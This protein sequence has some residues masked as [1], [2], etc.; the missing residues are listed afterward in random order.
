MALSNELFDLLI[1]KTFCQE[2]RQNFSLA[3]IIPL[4]IWQ[5]VFKEAVTLR[6]INIITKAYS[7]VLTY[8]VTFKTPLLRPLQTDLGQRKIYT[9]A[10]L[11]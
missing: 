6:L 7:I 4:K 5:Y 11:K 1:T 2:C 9:V 3:A 10:V 8:A